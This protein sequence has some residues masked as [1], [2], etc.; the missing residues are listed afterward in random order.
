M[1]I[2]IASGKGG[3]GKTTVA[4]NLAVT[5][6]REMRVGLLDCDVEEPNCHLYLRPPFD[7]DEPVW[8]TNPQIDPE[9]CTGC[10][11]CARSCRFHAL[12]ALPGRPLLMPEL[13]HGCGVCA[14]VCPNHAISDTVREVG[15]VGAGAVGRLYLRWGRLH[16]GQARSTPLIRAVKD[17]SGA[18]AL[19]LVIIDAPPGVACPAVEAM[20]GADF[21][22]LVAEPSRF[23][24]Y[25][26][27]LAIQTT[28]EVGIPTGVVINRVG[29]AESGIGQLCLDERIPI[30]L[31]IPE[32]RRIAEAGSRGEAHA[33]TDHALAASLRG[34]ADSVRQLAVPDA[35]G[36]G[37]PAT[38]AGAGMAAMQ[39][40]AS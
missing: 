18:P 40:A 34:L 27:R 31:G 10:A 37:V 17:L 19:D 35:E 8:T 5:M 11:V 14:F 26:L 12:V 24:L 25:D 1:R 28:K 3:T 30:L 39:R 23:G 20:K 15:V 33:V 32:D 21:V 29:I 2:V 13:C 36:A 7:A 22:V 9:V 16:V 4:V 6:A 38:K